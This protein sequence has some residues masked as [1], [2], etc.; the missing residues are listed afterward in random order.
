VTARVLVVDDIEANRRLLQAKL[1]AQYYTVM[2]AENGIEALSMVE[3][4]E[5]DII[6]LDVMMPGMDGYE[7]CRRLKE[8][9]A[10]NHIPVVMV[11]ALNDVEDRVR[12]LEVGAEDFLTKPVDDFAL[13]ARM[14]ALTR[15][16]AVASELRQR[17]AS[18]LRAGIDGGDGVHVKDQPARLFVV[19]DNPR[20][21][22]RIADTLRSG[23]HTAIT[24]LEAGG[25]KG[26]NE[27]GVDILVLSMLSDRYD[28]LKLCAHFKMNEATRSISILLICDPDDRQRAGKGLDLG[29]SDVIFAPI[30]KQELLARVRTQARRTRY[31][32]MLR[33]RV[34]RGLEL[35]VIDQLTGLYNRRY[36]NNQLEQLMQRSLM[37]GRPVSVL[38]ADID[39]FKAVNDTYGHDAGDEVLQEMAKRLKTNSRVMD[40]VCRP[41]GE[42]FMV[43][44][45][46]TPGDLACAAA[47]RIRRSV[48]AEPFV[49]SGGAREISITL[50]AGVS[51]IRGASDTIADLIKRADTALYQAKAAGRNRVESIAA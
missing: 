6:L 50:S 16:N 32:E 39:H 2:L 44:M 33:D 8:N 11:T 3:R 35:S 10:T 41:G 4:S 25:M 5:P 29:A 40:V 46:D 36:M 45:P 27:L 26:L 18:G 17:Q 20:T 47:E 49:V 15:Y 23:G 43:I 28:A 1:E 24:L 31:I 12:G 34:D 7:V 14:G 9:P 42:E 30:E 38:M 51:T 19:D 13:M 48:A 37:G 22:T 21:S